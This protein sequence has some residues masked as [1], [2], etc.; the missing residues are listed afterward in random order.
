MAGKK[1]QRS[2]GHNA[3]TSAEHE[4]DGTYRKHRHENRADKKAAIGKPAKPADLDD[5]ESLV[6]DE[7]ASYLPDG[8]VG[9][10][11]TMA[12]REMCRWYS[13]Y[14]N[15]MAAIECNPL[16]KDARLS[17]TAYWDR[18]WRIAKDYGATPVERTR[19]QQ[20]SGGESDPGDPMA[21]LRKLLE[22]RN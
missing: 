21:S 18:F 12:L 5:I 7:V 9:R 11:D 13:V 20:Q 1:G 15:A 17:A 6:W 2:G 19:L 22:S 14:R 16:D 8:C 3:K 4:R 10:G